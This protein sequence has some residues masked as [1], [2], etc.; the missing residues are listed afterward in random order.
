MK[1]YARL[2]LVL[3]LSA[4]ALF[5]CGDS[6][7]ATSDSTPGEDT[8]DTG[9]ET[10]TGDGDG[11]PA[12]DGDGDT[13]GDGDGDTAGDGD[14][15]GDTAGD[16]DG[17]TAGDGDGDTAGDGDGDGD[18]TGDGDGDVVTDPNEDI[19]PPDADGCHAIYAQDQFP[20]FTIVL[21]Q[22][23]WEQLQYNWDN[24]E[25][26]QDDPNED[27]KSYL[28]IQAFHYQHPGYDPIEINDAEIRL[29]GNPINWDPLP[30]D[31][32]Q[33]QIGFHVNDVDG[34][35]LGLK[36][37]AFDAATFNRHMLRDRLALQVMRDAGV[38]ATCANSM[39]LMIDVEYPNPADEAELGAPF[40]YGVFTNL[41]KLDEIYLERAWGDPS[42]DLW[43]RSSWELKTNKD[44]SNDARLTALRQAGTLQS[45]DTYLD[46]EQSLRVFAAEAVLPNADGMWAGGLN[47]YF[48]DDPQT[49]KFAMLPWDLDN[50]FE[51]F[52]NDQNDPYPT[53]PD[54]IV[55][56]KPNTWGRPWYDIP[57]ED[58]EWFE[59]YIEQVREVVEQGYTDDVLHA[60]I[61]TWTDQISQSVYEDTFKP[62]SNSLYD[63]KVEELHDHVQSRYDDL[64]DWL[65]C[66]D[67]GGTP[68]NQGYC[69]P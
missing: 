54:P 5:A 24:G 35:F 12:G 33:F 50:G 27:P 39:R 2:I 28:P 43:K 14:G 3:P 45:L 20:E 9:S 34:R 10:A 44:T 68:N 6:S 66:W 63:D 31:K 40:F 49:G 48:Y 22:T 41:E 56:E 52:N 64:V 15:D 25:D 29:R 32:M 4:V 65:A 62:Y 67:G 37:L 26:L 59:F 8:S 42:G 30:D 1:N 61:D 55:W 60:R 17:D 57:M 53:N 36:R 11:D 58:S 46:F 18:A 16:G 69:V 23:V 38:K 13:A 47:Y 7:S 19:P 51:R 21:Q